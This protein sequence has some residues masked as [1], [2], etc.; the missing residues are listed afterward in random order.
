MFWEFH[1][2]FMPLNNDKHHFNVIQDM[3]IQWTHNRI[4]FDNKYIGF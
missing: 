3:K 2:N 1:T 4:K